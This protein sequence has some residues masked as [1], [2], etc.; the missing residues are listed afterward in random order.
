MSLMRRVSFLWVAAILAADAASAQSSTSPSPF[1]FSLA[2]SGESRSDAYQL[3]TGDGLGG[4][5]ASSA[6]PA[7]GAGGGA[8]Q[9]KQG[10]KK[11]ASHGFAFDLGAGFNAPIGNDTSKA[12][13]GPF[14]T[15]GGNLTAG[16]G[17]RFSQRLSLLGEFQFLDN[18]LPGSFI[19]E[20]GDGAT[21]GNTH[22]VSLTAEPVLELFPK[23]TY[24]IYLTGGGGYYHKS[25]NFN[26]QTCCDFYGYPVSV[27]TNSFS[28][29]QAGGNLGFGLDR[30][31]GGLYGDGKMKLF[32]EARYIF[33]DT[34]P[35]SQTN[36]L[37]KTELLP[38][39]IGLRW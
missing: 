18:K 17:L 21:N 1:K 11:V 20:A 24:D 9:Q 23:R 33:I 8:G 27:N 35:I 14:I 30:R 36:G 25:T 6:N 31:V 37:G 12:Y 15:W 34:P 19:A 22:I 13:G 5:T 32:A 29:N 26:V 28:S 4:A 39:T 2:S 16:G 10:W 3:L 38:V 7:A